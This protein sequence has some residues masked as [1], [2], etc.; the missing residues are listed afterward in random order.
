VREKALVV[1][2]TGPMTAHQALLFS[3]WS[4]DVTLLLNGQDAPTGE[5][6]A[7]LSAIGVAVVTG[8]V[9]EVCS[10]GG[11]ITGVMVETD[12][13]LATVQC[14]AVVVGPRFQARSAVLE[15]LGVSSVDFLMGEVA[16]GTHVPSQPMTGQTS[17]KGVYVAGNVTEPQA[18]VIHAAGA[19]VRTAAWVN[20]ELITEDADRAV[21]RLEESLPGS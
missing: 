5:A 4:A 19:G 9:H 10:S 6:A 1:I 16:V 13:G 14:Q 21:A 2:A 7:R 12:A 15:S 18:Q 11:R 17:V 8:A 3:Q 20:A